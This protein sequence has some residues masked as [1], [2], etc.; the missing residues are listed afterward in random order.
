[1][2]LAGQTL[3][4]KADDEGHPA[5]AGSDLRVSTLRWALPLVSGAGAVL[6]LVQ[7]FER[8]SLWYD[9]AMLSLSVA[10]RSWRE[11]LQ[12]LDFDQTAPPLFLLVQRGLVS[13][14]GVNELSLRLVSLLAGIALPPL[15]WLV[16]RRLMSA[17]AA[18]LVTTL[19]AVSP[20][21]IR[22]SNEAKPYGLDAT[23]AVAMS[24]LAIRVIE[25]PRLAVRWWQLAIAGVLALGASTAGL[26]M[27]AAVGLALLLAPPVRAAGRGPGK[28][29]ALGGLWCAVFIGLYS[30]IYSVAATNPFMQEFWEGGFLRPTADD[31]G[32]RAWTALNAVFSGTLVGT[33]D[34]AR[35]GAV[36]GAGVQVQAVVAALLCVVGALRFLSMRRYW[37]AALLTG[38]ALGAVGASAIGQ[39]PIA[40]RLL[41]FAV[42]GLLVLIVQGMGGSRPLTSVRGLVWLGLVT[43][44]LAPATIRGVMTSV[45]PIRQQD[46][47]P[48]IREWQQRRDP[49]EPVYVYA[50]AIPAWAFYSTDWTRPD[51]ARLRWLAETGGSHGP[52]FPNLLPRGRPVVWEG[53]ELTRNA[54]GVHEL[55]GIGA[56]RGVRWGRPAPEAPDSGWADN[57]AR[58]IRAAGDQVWLLFVPL[59]PGDHQPNLDDLQ[60][61][62]R[63][64]G[65]VVTAEFHAREADLYLYRFSGPHPVAPGSAPPHPQSPDSGP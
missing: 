5:P 23:I 13:V 56:G 38:P 49:A 55:L 37:V 59:W 2:H 18:L 63:Q 35:W 19:V 10:A 50:A 1:M 33:L 53:D 14:F 8:R 25:Q 15:T 9:E 7:F 47:R 17:R 3:P 36:I 52:A 64:R 16:A 46:V 58:R 41:L 24:L 27:L 32:A 45:A 48:L 22:Y 34:S 51:T 26:L 31:L 39:Y 43:L 21:L 60:S 28:A 30:R 57:E 61:A 11:L 12:P 6:R 62:L 29:I 20:M 42:P 4:V 54:S 40:G 44:F 65:A